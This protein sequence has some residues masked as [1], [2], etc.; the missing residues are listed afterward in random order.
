MLVSNANRMK[1]FRSVELKW[2]QTCCL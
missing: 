2:R 1:V